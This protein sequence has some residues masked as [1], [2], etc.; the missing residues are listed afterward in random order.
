[1]RCRFV[2]AGHITEAEFWASKKHA[3][4][5][6]HAKSGGGQKA[7]LSTQLLSLLTAPKDTTS[8]RPQLSITPTMEQQIFAEN[9]AVAAVYA[10]TV[11]HVRT[12]EKFYEQYVDMLRNRVERRRKRAAGM[13][14]FLLC[15]ISTGLMALMR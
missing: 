8:G 1:M 14:F 2:K 13:C 6:I 3:V 9:P 15:V 5:A 10:K 12:R 4:K 11:P 7:G